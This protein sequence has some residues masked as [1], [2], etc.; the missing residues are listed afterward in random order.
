M[1]LLFDLLFGVVV[2]GIA[3]RLRGDRWLNDRF[4]IG[5]AGARA[6]WA[7][8]VLVLCAAWLDGAVWGLPSWAPWAAI[9]SL[10]YVG[11]IFGQRGALDMGR[12]KGTRAGD[13]IQGAIRGLIFT[14]PIGVGLAL[15]G[16]SAAAAVVGL[17]GVLMPACY[18][19]GWRMPT[20]G[21]R[22]L[23]DFAWGEILFGAIIGAA[24]TG[25]LSIA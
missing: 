23:A 20:F 12:D 17:S 13:A 19:I 11:A 22:W 9:P 10:A 1:I 3:F 4:G 18:E 16:Q 14:V 21:R 24:I 25:G 8:A 2:G 5:T 15:A 7:L 6:V